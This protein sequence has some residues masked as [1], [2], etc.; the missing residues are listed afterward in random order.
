M[1]AATYRRIRAAATA[2]QSAGAATTLGSSTELALPAA[3]E[4]ARN[5]VAFERLR[6]VR[7]TV[8]RGSLEIAPER[9]AGSERR[10]GVER[11][12]A[13]RPGDLWHE[14]RRGADR[15][16]GIDR[17]QFGAPAPTAA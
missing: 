6:G 12:L 8:G 11:R 3:V 17:R 14:R 2:A 1:E 10:T 13:T 5:Y 7:I 4:Y 15:R 16:A 9:R